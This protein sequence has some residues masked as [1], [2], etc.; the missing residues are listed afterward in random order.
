MTGN[1]FL[2]NIW[3]FLRIFNKHAAA[4]RLFFMLRSATG[5]NNEKF[6]EL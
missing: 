3:W 6:N 5:S 4:G 2:I 1:S